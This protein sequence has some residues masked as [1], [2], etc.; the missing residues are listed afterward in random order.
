[1]A[2][3]LLRSLLLEEQRKSLLPMERNSGRAPAEVPSGG[4]SAR[5]VVSIQPGFAG[6][7]LHRCE[8][9]PL[10]MTDKVRK[11]ESQHWRHVSMAKHHT[12]ITTNSPPAEVTSGRN[13]TRKT[14]IGSRPPERYRVYDTAPTSQFHP[15]ADKSLPAYPPRPTKSEGLGLMPLPAVPPGITRAGGVDL[16]QR[17]HNLHELCYRYTSYSVEARA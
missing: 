7:P 1:M 12:N 3:P 17:P 8:N 14:A 13:K 4:S 5:V 9:I 6:P 2:G 10:L 16:F 11:R 15:G